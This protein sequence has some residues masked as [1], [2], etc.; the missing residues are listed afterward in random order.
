RPSRLR[1]WSRSASSA[2]P[3]SS[4]ASGDESAI[5]V[6]RNSVT[7]RRSQ[8]RGVGDDAVARAGR[9]GSRG[10]GSAGGGSGRARRGS[11]RRG[12]VGVDAAGGY[13]PRPPDF[14]V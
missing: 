2:R 10:E 6:A 4:S 12:G 14:S 5:S 8:R 3:V 11:G 9:G 13:T 7:R 1:A